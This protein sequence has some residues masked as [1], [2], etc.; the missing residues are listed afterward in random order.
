MSEEAERLYEKAR[1]LPPKARAG[2]IRRTCRGDPELREELLSLLERAEAAEEFFGL[3]GDAVVTGSFWASATG[4]AAESGREAGTD[5]PPSSPDLPRGHTIGHYQILERVGVGGMGTV[6]RARDTRLE[7]DVALKFLPPYLLRTEDEAEERLLNE[8]R[9][10]AALEHPNVCT[11]HEIGET[12]EGQ[13]FI[14]MAYYEGETLKQTLRRGALPPTQAARVT[15]QLARGLAA[16]HARGIVHRDVKPGN[17]MLAADGTVKLLDFG[18]AQMAEVTLVRPGVMRGTAPYMS[19][20]QIRGEPLDART[21]LWS[22]GVVLYEMLT[23]ERPF[24]GE[25]VRGLLQA[26]LHEDP[27]PVTERRPEIPAPLAR[28]VERLL[29]KEPDA[30]Y[31]SAGELEA[32]LARAVPSTEGMSRVAGSARRRRNL[33]VVGVAAVLVALVAG[34]LWLPGLGEES[35]PA[36]AIRTEPP[37][38]AVLPLT[39][40]GSGDR[41]S[42]LAAGMTE[43]LIA[44]LARLGGVRVIASTSVFAFEGSQMDVRRIADSLGVSNLVE[45]SLRKDGDR[46]RVQV[47]LVDG[48]DGSTRWSETYEREFQDVFEVQEAIARA[49][50][51]ELDLR[52]AEETGPKLVRHQTPHIA[53]YEFYLR[54][55]DPTLLRID[56]GVR[57][58]MEYFKH[59]IAVDST[60][61]AAHAGLARMQLLLA[62]KRDPELPTQEWQALAEQSALKAVALDDSLAE[63]HA[64]LGLVQWFTT[65]EFASAE[66]ELRRAIDLDPTRAPFREW[67]AQLYLQT[68]RSEEALAEARRAL[69]I[70]PLSASAQA[71]VAHALLANGRYD[72]AL[73][74]LERIA[75]VQ[76]PLLRAAP[77]AAQAYA[78]KGMWPEA[79][80][81]L[82][83]QAEKDGS[84]TLSVYG[85]LLGRAGRRDEALRV[86]ATLLDRW[87]N[88]KSSAFDVAI[89]H[90]GLGDLDQAFAWLHRSD[91][92][93]L[94]TYNFHIMEPIFQEL[95]SDPRFERIR[96]RLGF[97]KR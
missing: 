94:L 2:F 60:Y 36:V 72:E 84:R 47:R 71:E 35:A 74:G 13:P 46:L 14:A 22:L 65:Y 86:H 92:L 55:S 93:S 76:P 97:Q 44:I 34:A 19:P 95:R 67:L 96:E 73:A 42:S 58:G 33:A 27:E 7:R 49:V 31:V 43:E 45:G 79:I 20:E 39:D 62:A 91:D 1:A 63:A 3:L 82:R 32:D 21:D 18:L 81:A 29:Q 88:G 70:D 24:Q 66:T 87:R 37:S 48:R 61:A 15:L 53:A 77:Y 38:I 10:A 54:G 75:G 83:P 85:Y 56:G 23:G 9:A 11:V 30:R 69:E 80:S 52:L 68:G 90:A 12:E 89:V 6:Y 26:I 17:V 51:R 25:D 41:D 64:A 16:A 50:A 8:A 57:R 5:P 28:I 59:S 4:G 40:L 78:L